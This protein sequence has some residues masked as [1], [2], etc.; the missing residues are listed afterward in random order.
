[1]MACHTPMSTKKKIMLFGAIGA[2]IAAIAYFSYTTNNPTL[3]ATI[4]AIL[5]FAVCPAMCAG[6]GGAMWLAN[7]S[8]KNK[9]QTTPQS[10]E[11]VS[12]NH[13]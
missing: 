2:A 12:Q 4:P 3:A 7:R 13:S 1:M 11:Q 6:M 10:N 5:T 9:N 8:K